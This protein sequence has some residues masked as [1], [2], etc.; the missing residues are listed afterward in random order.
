VYF[1]IDK[2]VYF[3]QIGAAWKQG[4][5]IPGNMKKRMGG[6]H[7]SINLDSEQPYQQHAVHVRQYPPGR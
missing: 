1:D 6:K 4:R 7:V 3:Y 5:D 2:K